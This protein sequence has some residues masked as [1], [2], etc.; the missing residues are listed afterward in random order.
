MLSEPI[1]EG[2]MGRVWRGRDKLLNRDVAVKE[3]PLPPQ[4]PQ[5]NGE[6]AAR[7]LREARAAARLDHPGVVTIH[8]VVEH[9]DALW[10]IMRLVPGT[11][12]G[13]EI[14]LHGRLPW[15]RVALIA[16]QAAEVL[17]R[18]HGA[19]LTHGDLKPNNILLTGAPADTVVLTDFGTARIREAGTRLAGQEASTGEASCLAPEQLEG[20][21][22]GPP[23]DMWAL[24]A[25]LYT[26]V[27][28]REPFTGSAAAEGRAAVLA[29][30]LTM[31]EFAGPLRDLIG[32]L[33]AEG[34]GR[35]PRRAGGAVCPGRPRRRERG[36]PAARCDL[37]R[38]ER[39]L[40]AVALRRVTAG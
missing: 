40:D 37:A 17:A 23:A 22:A 24:G 20:G 10:I 27:E 6:L 1:G 3:I 9:G 36:W 21:D 30:P 35:P 11:S 8:D 39:R 5:E 4:S 16:R 31:P 34:P 12:L 32:A 2:G 29:T 25:T 28:G 19:G 33:L 15:P 38:R 26:A 13:A 14:G 18:A 7:V